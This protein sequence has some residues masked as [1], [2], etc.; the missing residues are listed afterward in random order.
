M[1]YQYRKSILINTAL[2]GKNSVSASWI[3]WFCSSAHNILFFFLM[4]LLNYVENANLRQ[5]S[6]LAI[7]FSFF[8][9]F[10]SLWYSLQYRCELE[11]VGQR[12]A[13][14]IQIK[15]YTFQMNIPKWNCS[16][17]ADILQVRVFC[18]V[19]FCFASGLLGL[20]NK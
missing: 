14:E 10:C 7:F 9:F 18:F 2:K 1:I 5:C 6:H 12:L 17:N 16:C 8:L 3:S 19:L 4:Q 20:K 15:K 13:W 11:N